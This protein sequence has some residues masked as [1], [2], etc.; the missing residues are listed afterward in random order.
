LRTGLDMTLIVRNTGKKN[1]PDFLQLRH[2][3]ARETI[4]S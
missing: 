3:P 2:A 1:T 4:L